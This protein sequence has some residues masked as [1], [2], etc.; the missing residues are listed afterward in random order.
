MAFHERQRKSPPNY[1][2]ELPDFYFDD[3]SLQDV[4]EKFKQHM[5][6]REGNGRQ[7]SNRF[8]TFD[9][10][11]RMGIIKAENG[12][13]KG[14]G[15]NGKFTSADGKTVTVRDGLITSIQA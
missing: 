14:G 13:T 1:K 3:S 15:A 5:E 9:E 11:E 7:D 4:L 2:S 12:V 6:E 8:V 10:L